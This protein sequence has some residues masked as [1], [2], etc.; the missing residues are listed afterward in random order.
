MACFFAVE[1]SGAESANDQQSAVSSNDSVVKGRQVFEKHRCTVCHRPG[2]L[3]KALEGI[4]QRLKREEIE[5]WIADPKKSKPKTIMP[6]FLLK[7]DELEAV[8]DYVMSLK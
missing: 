6:K 1:W 5:A 2:G 3:G 7:D 4:A 8:T